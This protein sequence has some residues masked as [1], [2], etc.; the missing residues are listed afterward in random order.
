MERR[1]SAILVAD[2]V[3]FSRLM[4]LAEE[5]TVLRQNVLRAHI[6]DPQIAS[7]AGRLVKSM[8]DGVLVEFASAVQAAESAIAIQTELAQW[9]QDTPEDKRIRYRIGI[10]V[11]D[12]IVVGD[13]L[14]GDGVNV[15]A[16]L[17]T[18]AAPGGICISSTARDHIQ[19]ELGSAFKDGGDQQLKNISRPVRVFNWRGQLPQEGPAPAPGVK[20]GKPRVCLGP[21]AV[22]GGGDESRFLAD[23]CRQNVGAA[24]S[25]L[26]GMTLIG[27]ES[28]A[29]HMAAASF[30]V[31]AGKGRVLLQLQEPG[32]ATTYASYRFDADLEDPVAAL[33][34][35]SGLITSAIRYGVAER[36]SGVVHEGLCADTDF[37]A[38]LSRIAYILM[39][40]DAA[41]WRE[42]GP[43]LDALDEASPDNFMI[44]AMKAISLLREPVSGYRRAG[45]DSA[46]AAKDCARRALKLNN[47]SD[48]VYVACANAKFFVDGDVAGAVRDIRRS[49]D[50]T[51]QYPVGLLTLGFCQ[52]LSGEVNEGLENLELA[53]AALS[54]SRIYHRVLYGAAVG[55]FAVED[56]GRCLET[57]EQVLQLEPDLVQPM[58]FEAAAAALDGQADLAVVRRADILELHTRLTIGAVTALPFQDKQVEARFL[59]GLRKAGLPQ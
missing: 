17:E 20:R 2:I 18:L 48:F 55:H 29:D 14:F 23:A 43:M 24:L 1:L 42:A 38:M 33:D 34:K 26:T 31:V 39:G 21:F 52:V 7:R 10:S 58:L 16:R 46:Q 36:E 35:L 49:L 25:N 15:A 6:I 27:A 9:E 56:C 5:E 4:E 51:P 28:E 45:P 59:E 3:G 57:C 19:G 37:E 32:S 50:I 44:L 40:S 47:R 12:V 22:L 54:R 13:D 41:E 30:Q 53:A 11:D 8:G